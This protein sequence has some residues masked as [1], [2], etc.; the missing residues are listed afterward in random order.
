MAMEPFTPPAADAGDAAAYNRRGM[1]RYRLGDFAGAVADYD[2]ALARQADF[3]EALNNRGAAHAAVGDLRAA[4]ADYNAALSFR[5]D[6][7]EAHN[8]RGAARH[9]LNDLAGALA[10]FDRA[11]ELRP[12]YAEAYYNRGTVR[13][14]QKDYGGA[15]E[16]FGR[17]IQLRPTDAAGYEGRA[18]VYY[19][20]WN[21]AAAV[22]DYDRT[23]EL[24]GRT[25]AGPARLWRAYVYRGDAR[26]HAGDR[27]GL[28]DDYRRGFQ[29]DADMAAGLVITR[30]ADD[31]RCNLAAVLAD[32]AKHLRLAPDDA[33]THARRGLVRLLQG[34]EAEAQKDFDHFLALNPGDRDQLATLIAR[35]EQQRNSPAPRVPSGG[36]RGAGT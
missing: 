5:P 6:Y 35:A 8:N 18:E 23:L 16:D 27:A 4:V 33:V 9:A 24:L 11:V 34:R 25:S 7:P 12:E 26:Y 22:A 28:L 1:A 15:V 36:P 29:I 10:D 32:C 19:L 20:Q 30:L 2:E 17:V 14:A 31:I 3:A 13:Q 21:H